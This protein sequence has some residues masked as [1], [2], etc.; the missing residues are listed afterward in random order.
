MPP[1][2][3][4][5]SLF[6]IRLS[7]EG[8]RPHLIPAGDL[9]HLLIAAEQMVMGLAAREHPED[10][11]SLF[12]GLAAVRDESIGFVFTSNRPDSALAVY[13][14]LVSLTGNSFALST[15]QGN[16]RFRRAAGRR[17]RSLRFVGRRGLRAQSQRGR[18]AM[19]KV[20]L[21]NHIGPLAKVAEGRIE[22]RELPPLRPRQTDLPF[23][24]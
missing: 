1:T 10:A 24:P 7:G 8:V 13:Q 14:E 23:S 2:E 5:Q 3:G 6:T 22:I 17:G 9:A 4:M 19:T 12:V 11:D 18:I 20:C 16:V 21:D 15:R